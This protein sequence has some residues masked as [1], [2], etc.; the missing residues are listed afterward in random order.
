LDN[1]LVILNLAVLHRAGG[2]QPARAAEAETGEVQSVV[3][4]TPSLEIDALSLYRSKTESK[5][6]LAFNNA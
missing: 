1:D 6:V 4:P 2:R 3:L 5:G